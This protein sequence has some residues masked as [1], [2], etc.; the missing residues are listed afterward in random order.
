M[1]IA[2]AQNS[3]LFVTG[4]AA[5]LNAATAA[6]HKPKLK[7]PARFSYCLAIQPATQARAKRKR[8]HILQ[9]V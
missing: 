7:L 4:G 9:E 5:R 3:V 1:A 6:I 2:R 8:S